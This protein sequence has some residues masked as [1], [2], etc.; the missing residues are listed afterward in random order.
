MSSK[1]EQIPVP[2][3]IL[4]LL[5][6]QPYETWPTNFN[7][8]NVASKLQHQKI[9]VGTHTKSPFVRVDD[10]ENYSPY[11]RAQRFSYVIPFMIDNVVQLR[12]EKGNFRQQ[13]LEMESTEE[14]LDKVLEKLGAICDFIQELLESN[15]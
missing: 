6:T 11:R 14:R 15:I 1:E 8:E 10:I 5:P 2:T 9:L 4:G 13:L 3:Q 12:N 7:L